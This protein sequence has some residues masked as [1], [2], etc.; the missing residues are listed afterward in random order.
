MVQPLVS[1]ECILGKIVPL[2]CDNVSYF[3]VNTNSAY[4]ETEDNTS[5]TWVIN[6]TQ[7]HKTD[8]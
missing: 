7:C 6:T 2:C 4:A 3:Q 1:K 5:N 8:Y